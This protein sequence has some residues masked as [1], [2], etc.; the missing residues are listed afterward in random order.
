MWLEKK[1]NKT[2]IE[3]LKTLENMSV[4]LLRLLF[5]TAIG[6]L[7]SD[8]EQSFSLFK[9]FLFKTIFCHLTVSN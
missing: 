1:T 5:L 7:N 4:C 2:K 8:I 3:R 6:L 9:L